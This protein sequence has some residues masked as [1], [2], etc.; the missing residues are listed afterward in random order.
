MSEVEAE[1]PVEAPVAPVEAPVEAPVV[2]A[3]VEP[4]E[5][6]DDS[7]PAPDVREPQARTLKRL[8]LTVNG[9]IPAEDRKA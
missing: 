7:L 3:P 8:G 5:A 2:E 1:V 6:E 9:E 4:E